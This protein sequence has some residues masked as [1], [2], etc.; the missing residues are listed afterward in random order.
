MS[1]PL[2]FILQLIALV[3]IIMS[4]NIADDGTYSIHGGYMFTGLVFVLL[5][6]M[7]YRSRT[8]KG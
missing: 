7:G 4:I 5:G 6:G 3:L 2:S 1:K 8:K